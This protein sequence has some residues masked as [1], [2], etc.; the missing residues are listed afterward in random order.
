MP[1]E[2]NDQPNRTRSRWIRDC[3]V[4]FGLLMALSLVL[5]YVIAGRHQH[6]LISPPHSGVTLQEFQAQRGS[7]IDREHVAVAAAYGGEVVVVTGKLSPRW[8]LPSGPPIY[9]FDG[10][11]G[12]LIDWTSDSGDDDRF[13]SAWGD[14]LK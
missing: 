13:K 6:S 14:V 3:V 11:N 1:D 8:M 10:A 9:V 5:V 2:A 4:V 12:I 7:I